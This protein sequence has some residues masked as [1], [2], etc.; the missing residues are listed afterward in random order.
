M[1]T[2]AE[3]KILRTRRENDTMAGNI[4][5]LQKLS[6]Q[7]NNGERKCAVKMQTNCTSGLT[8]DIVLR[9]VEVVNDSITLYTEPGEFMYDLNTSSWEYIDEDEFDVY[10]VSEENGNEYSFCLI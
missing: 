9:D 5:I 2:N 10:K 8:L 7:L 4:S 1:E 6:E 3:Q